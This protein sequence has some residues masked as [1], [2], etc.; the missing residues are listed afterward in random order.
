MMRVVSSM[1][2]SLQFCVYHFTNKCNKRETR[3]QHFSTIPFFSP[4]FYN[5]LSFIIWIVFVHTNDEEIC[6]ANLWKLWWTRSEHKN[7]KIADDENYWISS[8][9]KC[10][11]F[12]IST[13]LLL[14]TFIF[15]CHVFVQNQTV[16]CCHSI[17]WELNE[18]EM[19]FNFNNYCWK[20]TQFCENLLTSLHRRRESLNFIDFPSIYIW[21]KFNLSSY[22]TH[23]PQLNICLSLN[24]PSSA[25]FLMLEL[26]GCCFVCYTHIFP[27]THK[28]C[29]FLST[30]REMMIKHFL[31]FSFFY[32][33]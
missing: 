2:C 29:R 25:T 13:H 26:F 1:M 12:H 20:H 31:K 30:T 9:E 15:F 28:F 19:N 18:Y 33:L 32:M 23:P 14:L 16:V 22:S 27:T 6:F 5:T 11:T 17:E 24:F 4:L 10:L 3:A 8:S 7:P 21:M